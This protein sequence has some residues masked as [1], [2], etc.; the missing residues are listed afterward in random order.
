MEPT[1]I[2]GV[3]SYMRSN[4]SWTKCSHRNFI[5]LLEVTAGDAGLDAMVFPDIIIHCHLVRHRDPPNP[6]A[7]EKERKTIN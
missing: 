6:P 2:N 4:A 5:V 1:G 3:Y 7:P